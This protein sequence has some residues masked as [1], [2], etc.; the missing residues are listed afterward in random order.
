MAVLT[1]GFWLACLSEP[2]AEP[3]P[4]HGCH[5]L[6][7]H[8]SE[9]TECLLGYEPVMIHMPAIVAGDGGKQ[10][11]GLTVPSWEGLFRSL[12]TPGFQWLL[13]GQQLA[14]QQKRDFRWR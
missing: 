14:E 7:H 4:Q 11:A 9:V 1:P 5:L 8:P 2:Q 10:K 6:A 13:L 3:Y 12:Q